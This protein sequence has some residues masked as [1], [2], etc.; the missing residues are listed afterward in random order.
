M[1]SKLLKNSRLLGGETRINLKKILNYQIALVVQYLK[2]RKRDIFQAKNKHIIKEKGFFI[3]RIISTSRE[4]A[5]KCTMTMSVHTM[6]VP[7]QGTV[8]GTVRGGRA[9]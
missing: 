7:E 2:M 3:K 6:L 4:N 8:I 1:F 9:G 5:V